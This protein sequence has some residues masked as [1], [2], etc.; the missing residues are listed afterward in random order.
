MNKSLANLRDNQTT[1]TTGHML[2][3]SQ[4][5]DIVLTIKLINYQENKKT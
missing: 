1:H 2:L 4:R 3:A 5:A